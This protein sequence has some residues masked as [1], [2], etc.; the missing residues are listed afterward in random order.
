MCGRKIPI[1]RNQIRIRILN[2]NASRFGNEKK[3]TTK[4]N[5]QLNMASKKDLRSYFNVVSEKKKDSAVSISEIIVS[6][7]SDVSQAEV[8]M[9]REQVKKPV[10]QR[11]SYQVVPEKVKIEV[12]RYAALNG[13]KATLKRYSKIYPK[14]TPRYTRSMI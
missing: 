3:R 4:Q 5:R 6:E 14:C 9:A 2:W 7:T 12:G 11:K 8:D 13:T 1:E 10:M